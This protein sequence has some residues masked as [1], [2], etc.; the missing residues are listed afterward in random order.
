MIRAVM[1][2]TGDEFV[3]VIVGSPFVPENPG[4]SNNTVPSA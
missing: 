2:D 3:Q 4:V 1:P